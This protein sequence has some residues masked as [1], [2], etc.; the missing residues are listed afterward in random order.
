MFVAAGAR[1]RLL[2]ERRKRFA[3]RYLEPL[4]AEASRLG[5]SADELAAM[6]RESSYPL[7]GTKQ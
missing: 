1:T 5:I 2:G 4:V 6:I 7:G 3:E